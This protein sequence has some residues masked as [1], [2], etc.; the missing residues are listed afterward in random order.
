MYMCIYY[1]YI[2]HI[3][4]YTIF[5]LIEKAH[6]PLRSLACCTLETLPFLSRW[7]SASG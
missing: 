5:Y 6:I 4:H 7:L 2:S 3:Y 1:F